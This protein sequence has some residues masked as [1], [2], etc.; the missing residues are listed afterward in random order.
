MLALAP[1]ARAD[2][3]NEDLH[4]PQALPAAPSSAAIQPHGVR[5]CRRASIRCIDGLMRRLEA[6]WRPLDAACDHRALFSLSYLRIT[7]GLRE[8]LA[9][10]RTPSTT[11][12]THTPRW[13]CARR[14]ASRASTITTA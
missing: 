11:C 2:H 8:D 5:N 6:Q 14:T 3:Q 13:A 4:W 7:A 9:R 12:P 10:P 1:I